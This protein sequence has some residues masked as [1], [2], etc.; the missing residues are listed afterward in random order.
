MNQAHLLRSR[1][2]ALILTG[3]VARSLPRPGMLAIIQ[4]VARTRRQAGWE[5]RH[6]VVRPR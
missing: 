1:S 5:R 4:L 6:I 3:D 2:L